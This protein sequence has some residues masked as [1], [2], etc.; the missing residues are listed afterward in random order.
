MVST[1]ARLKHES[2]APKNVVPLA[3][4]ID[5]INLSA[6]TQKLIGCG[7]FNQPRSRILHSVY[8]DNVL[9]VLYDELTSSSTLLALPNTDASME[10]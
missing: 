9:I 8:W 10:V 5:V 4:Y 1:Y 7:C 3:F 6:K 2:D